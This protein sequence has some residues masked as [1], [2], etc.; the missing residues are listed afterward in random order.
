MRLKVSQKIFIIGMVPL[1]AFIGFAA[2]HIWRSLDES[3]TMQT[4]LLN[5]D[6]V[7][8]ASSTI[9]D[10]QRERGRTALF[11]SGT[12][13]FEEVEALRKTTDQHMSELLQTLSHAKIPDEAKQPGADI[14]A[15][16]ESMRLEYNRPNSGLRKQEIRQYTEFIKTLLQLQTGAANAKTTRGFGKVLSSLTLLEAAKESAG[17]LR[18]W[19]SSILAEDKPLGDE[20]FS[21]VLK[22]KAETDA[23]LASP[24]L[25]LKK[26][27]STKLKEL[28][29]SE[30]WVETDNIL[31]TII[32]K[33]RTGNYG[34]SGNTF[35]STISNKLDG[36]SALVTMEMEAMSSQLKSDAA[37]VRQSQ[38]AVWA[39]A[40]IIC[41]FTIAIIW[42]FTK[43]TINRL[44]TLTA[45]LRDISEGEGNLTVRLDASAQDEI[46]MLSA[47]FNKFVEKIQKLVGGIVEQTHTLAST[48]QVLTGVASHVSSRST[49]TTDR[50]STVAAAAE[51][52]SANTASVASG[53]EQASTNLTS[54]ACATEEMSATVSE[55]AANSEK[56]RA[57]TEQASNQAQSISSL[58]EEFGRAAREIG[59]VVE[60]ITDISSQTNLLA[61]NATIEAARAGEAGKGFAVVA[62]EI[63]ELARQTAAATEDIK[64]KITGVQTSSGSAISDIEKIVGVIN[65][66]GG[67]V[68]AIA[69]AIEQQATVTKEVAGNISRATEGVKDASDRV[70]QTA[71]VSKSIAQDISSVNAAVE[72]I[73]QNG[74][75]VQASA[76]E[77]STLAERLNTLAAQFSI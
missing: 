42:I 2:F 62:N 3:T 69:A 20:E 46:G 6:L 22:L 56:A 37:D 51:E 1:I 5:I 59:K 47:Y 8:A 57:I 75:Q 21:I 30:S 50:T 4:M 11:L 13:K 54:V 73:A 65:E 32:S 44:K 7:K 12:S 18:A 48:A 43:D 60:T 77:L 38:L 26:E 49:E 16:L 58:M 66:I 23:H 45:S 19:G 52:M 53:V 61:L 74:Q 68:T 40:I 64:T 70:G 41:A 36:I 76:R 31:K 55:I 28:S 24:A 39:T 25:I 67:I 27:T 14:A 72:A 71:S 33:S 29:K 63:K 34:I 35:F 9:N 17:Q 15:R 10:V